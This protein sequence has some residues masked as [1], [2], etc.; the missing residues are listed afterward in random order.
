MGFYYIVCVGI[1]LPCIVNPVYMG[2]STRVY[3]LCIRI[4]C[5]YCIYGREIA[6][7]TVIYGVYIQGIYG[8]YTVFMAGKLPN[9]QSNTV[10]IYNS[11]QPIYFTCRYAILLN[12]FRINQPRLQKIVDIE[13][14]VCRA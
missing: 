7:Y 13:C 1:L 8:V 3:I 2:I 5:I 4:R 14:I 10:Y 6:K 9:T 12:P 11:G